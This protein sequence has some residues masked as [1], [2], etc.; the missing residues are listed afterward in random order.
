MEEN[1][2]GRDLL[3]LATSHTDSY[4]ELDNDNWFYHNAS[5]TSL[6]P[7]VYN[8]LMREVEGVA[9][10]GVVNRARGFEIP[11]D[12]ALGMVIT[13]PVSTTIH[14]SQSVDHLYLNTDTD[15]DGYSDGLEMTYGT[16]ENDDT[17][18][19][20]FLV[21]DLFSDSIA[22]FGGKDGID[23]FLAYVDGEEGLF[24]S[25]IFDETGLKEN[26]VYAPAAKFVSPLQ[27]T[28]YHLITDEYGDW[29]KEDLSS[30]SWSDFSSAL[31]KTTIFGQEKVDMLLEVKNISETYNYLLYD[32]SED[33]KGEWMRSILSFAAEQA[34]FDDIEIVEI[35]KGFDDD[36]NPDFNRVDNNEYKV[37]LDNDGEFVFEGLKEDYL[38]PGETLRIYFTV[39]P[40]FRQNLI[41]ATG[42]FNCEFNFMVQSNEVSY[43][44][45]PQILDVYRTESYVG[46]GIGNED[47]TEADTI[48]RRAKES[49]M[50]NVV[51]LTR[52]WPDHPTPNLR[53]RTRNEEIYIGDVPDGETHIELLENEVDWSGLAGVKKYQ[54]SNNETI[55]AIRDRNV[56]IG[57]GVNPVYLP[58]KNLSIVVI[59]GN[60][61]IKSNILA[62]E[63]EKES[64]G[65]GLVAL[66]E[67]VASETND[68]LWSDPIDETRR[69]EDLPGGNL[70]L[71]PEQVTDIFANI[72]IEGALFNVDSNDSSTNE[73][74]LSSLWD[75]ISDESSM[76]YHYDEDSNNIANQLYIHG[77]FFA[78]E[79]T[80]RGFNQD[81]PFSELSGDSY[82]R[83]NQL[84]DLSF[85]RHFIPGEEGIGDRANSLPLDDDRSFVIEYATD[86]SLPSI[87]RTH[88]I[89]RMREG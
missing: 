41:M 44:C 58:E 1:M 68:P 34:Q 7:T 28:L 55:Y 10:D 45:S 80:F 18:S 15:G 60:I 20:S 12:L 66:T 75:I 33:P 71:D 57:N 54:T 87:F 79:N 85:L 21:P 6:A 5:L 76:S 51:E 62:R 22:E 31:A 29:Q 64:K 13:D 49:L 36:V 84:L 17:D 82:G 14:E 56:V 25:P 9:G 77:L 81:R 86:Y 67:R 52:P 35:S 65:F 42:Y 89:V 30:E 46:A 26:R 63:D 4:L 83:Y 2:P 88:D 74:H 47:K 24:F 43:P 50:S 61:I 37:G 78:E 11:Y 69:N 59:G 39:W 32:E 19:P 38:E 70:L 48:L 27:A 73:K 8:D 53:N 40:G 16:D 23:T 3:A 72:F